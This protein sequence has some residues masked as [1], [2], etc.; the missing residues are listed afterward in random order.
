MSFVFLLENH[1]QLSHFSEQKFRIRHIQLGAPGIHMA[2]GIYKYK[3]Q[4]IHLEIMSY[5]CQ[6]LGTVANAS[7]FL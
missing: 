6:N 5:Q 7:V 2:Q 3:A 1:K 4:Q